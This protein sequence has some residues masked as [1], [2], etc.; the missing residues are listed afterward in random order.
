MKNKLKQLLIVLVGSVGLANFSVPAVA[1]TDFQPT[2]EISSAEVR[3]LEL[4]FDA[5]QNRWREYGEFPKVAMAE[6]RH[7][8]EIP[9]T[10]YSSE[11]WQTD[12]TPFITAS[13]TH[14]RDGIVATNFLP[15]GTRV[16]IPELYGDKIF[17]VED[18]MNRRYTYH[19][20][21]WM[22]E[23]PDAINFGLQFATVEIF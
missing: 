15:I 5:I 16:R 19:M 14:V 11:P 21:I 20:D 4:V 13:N 23:T 3:E 18:R 6:P 12:S 7:S 8:I 10:A 22:S 9:I 2:F 17:I 1:F